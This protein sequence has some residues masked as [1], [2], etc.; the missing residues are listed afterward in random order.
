MDWTIKD[1]AHANHNP[2]I[3]VDN[4]PGK[5]N[6]YITTRLGKTVVLDAQGPKD[7]GGNKLSYQWLAY[8]EAGSATSKQVDIAEVQGNRGEEPLT[9]RPVLA[10]NPQ[11]AGKVTVIPQ[12]PGV[13][14]IILAVRDDGLPSLT[15]YRRIIITVNK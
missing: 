5:D 12:R 3:V 9:T 8:R 1:F 4:Q 15:S 14:H 7:P 6:I 11:D 2:A 10:L 13:E